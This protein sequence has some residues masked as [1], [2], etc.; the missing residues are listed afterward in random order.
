MKQA[1]FVIIDNT[2]ILPG[3]QY[4]FRPYKYSIK[5]RIYK[6]GLKCSAL[7]LLAWNA[8]EKKP[9]GVSPGVLRPQPFAAF[10]ASSSMMGSG[11]T[12]AAHAVQ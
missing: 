11:F 8:G 7:L 6:S 4:D 9:P 3:N 5:R 10:G 12:V 1:L 2:H